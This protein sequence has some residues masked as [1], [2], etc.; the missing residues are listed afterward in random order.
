LFSNSLPLNG[1]NVTVLIVAILMFVELFSPFHNSVHWLDVKVE[2]SGEILPS[3]N[4]RSSG[5]RLSDDIDSSSPSS[6]VMLL[7]FPAF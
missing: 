2:K 7:S 6:K 1:G 3:V 4:G 5:S